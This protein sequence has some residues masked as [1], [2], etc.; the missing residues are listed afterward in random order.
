M[1]VLQERE[2]KVGGIGGLLS[3]FAIGCPVCN[4]LLLLALGTSG[5]M[6]YFAPVQPFL[7]GAGVLLLT[8]ALIVRL[9]NSVSCA[10]PTLQ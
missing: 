7:A 5:A 9:K 1:G 3:F 8:W 4:K 6:N 10:V 2:V